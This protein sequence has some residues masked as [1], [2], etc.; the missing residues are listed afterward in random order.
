MLLFTCILW[1]L[2]GGL[3]IHLWTKNPILRDNFIFRHSIELLATIFLSFYFVTILGLGLDSCVPLKEKLHCEPF[4]Y[5]TIMVD[6]STSSTKADGNDVAQPD[7][8]E[9]D[10]PASILW[11]TYYLLI[12]SGNQHSYSKNLQG[13]FLVG[14]LGL[15]SLILLNGL[16]ISAVMTTL[17][18]H[19]EKWRD[20]VL[21]YKPKALNGHL[22]IIGG[23][24]MVASI[25]EHE[26]NRP[27]IRTILIL[28]SRNVDEFR[29]EL[30]A[31]LTVDESKRKDMYKIVIYY[32]DRSSAVDIEKLYLD[33]ASE[34]FV[35]GEESSNDDAD[36]YH[37]TLNMS[38]VQHITNCLNNR[39]TKF[40]CHVMFEYQT[41][42][43]AL[44]LATEGVNKFRI[45]LK[46]FNY[47]EM[48]CQKCFGGDY[49]DKNG[50]EEY[51]IPLDGE[52]IKE[53][54]DTFVH[55]VIIGM[56]RMGVAMGHTAAHLAHYPNFITKGVRSR[57]TFID[58]NAD[59]ERDFLKGRY[60][61]LFKLARYR[62]IDTTVEDFDAN[63]DVT[64]VNEN[65]E[66]HLGKDFIDVEWEFV[67]GGIESD[68]VR[69]Y[70]VKIAENENARLT[71][72]VCLP[73]S[74]AAVA[75][76]IYLP[77]KIYNKAQQVLVYQRK[78]GVVVDQI[79]QNNKRYNKKLRAFGMIGKC[80]DFDLIEEF[81]ALG[82]YIGKK[83]KEYDDDLENNFIAE[84]PLTAEDDAAKKKAFDEI[85]AEELANKRVQSAIQ[86]GLTIPQEDLNLINQKPKTH[87]WQNYY[88]ILTLRSKMRSCG[89]DYRTQA[90]FAPEHLA[91]LGQVEHNRWLTEKLLQGFKP[92]D[93]DKQKEFYSNHDGIVEGYVLFT[94]WTE[95]CKYYKKKSDLKKDEHKHLD[96]CSNEILALVDPESVGRDGALIEHLPNALYEHHTGKQATTTK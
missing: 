26:M 51:Y 39:T 87:E 81:E 59:T 49:K 58:T 45:E 32:G 60:H 29:R 31:T 62:T 11:H 19:K 63:K 30:K 20:G 9:K 43:A 5:D 94:T 16:L 7:R 76:A 56:S 93:I 69:Q 13:R 55:L 3:M 18:R 90:S 38:C 33:K 6:E 95:R 66:S 77:D 73:E 41:T 8:V 78:N 88:N 74:N 86:R 42:F 67:K 52:G 72:A 24:D 65:Y 75:T 57:I 68:S 35:L 36:S 79:S 25:I 71:V 84:H 82:S 22:V 83:Y 10:T 48:W 46:P 17:D 27:N 21:R 12:D 96:I 53:Q 23:N 70:L 92:L 37:D 2:W 44:Q 80:Y 40:S 54:D 85:T 64:W 50:K 4:S 1:G 89:L 34:V 47:Y 15:F 61:E 91:I 28:T 14:F